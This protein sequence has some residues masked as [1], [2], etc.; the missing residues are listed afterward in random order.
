M[1][2]KDFIENYIEENKTYLMGLAQDIWSYRELSYEEKKST[3]VL[4]NALEEAGFTVEA[5]ISSMPTA[6]VASYGQSGPSFGFLGEYD[7]LPGLE[8][9]PGEAKKDPN[10]CG[11]GHGCGHNLLGVG[12]LGAALAAKAYM[13]KENIQARVY[14]FGCPAEEGTG[15][16][17]FMARDG[18]FDDMD[19]VYTWHPGDKNQVDYKISLAIQAIEFSF[20]GTAAHAGSSPWLGRSALDGAEIMSIGANYLREHIRDGERVHYAYMDAGG[21]AANVVQDRAKV[22]YEVRSFNLESL[23]KLY[24]RLIKCGEG[25]ALMTETELSYETTM[26]FADY[27]PNP[28]LADLAQEALEEVGPPSWTDEDYKLAKSYLSSYGQE[29][30]DSLEEELRLNGL[31]AK[32]KIEKPLD[33]SVRPYSNTLSYQSGSTDVGNVSYRC[34]TISYTIASWCLGNVGHTWQT[35]GQAGSILGQKGMVCA[36]KAMALGAIKTLASPESIEKAKDY[37]KNE[38]G[39]NYKEPLPRNLMPKYKK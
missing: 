28:Y 20:S 7:A 22:K 35:T 18:V 16:K 3:Q 24:Q 12:S 32:D 10:L 1:S 6:F 4:I 39:K 2:A 29:I 36:A 9:R 38:K 37:V 26:V 23:D 8:A 30:R 34:P 13:E 33:D 17:T 14:Y 11:P 15:G 19:F 27:A 25:A 21:E 31:D 5:G